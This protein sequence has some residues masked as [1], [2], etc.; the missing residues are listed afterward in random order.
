MILNPFL[1]ETTFIKSI[2]FFLSKVVFI[3]LKIIFLVFVLKT[4]NL[5]ISTVRFESSI[6]IIG[7]LIFDLIYNFFFESLTFNLGLSLIMV[8]ELTNIAQDCARR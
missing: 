6:T 2:L 5:V 7:C 8:F 4:L 3:E 1:F